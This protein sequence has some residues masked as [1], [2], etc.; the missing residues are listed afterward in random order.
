[1]F[2]SPAGLGPENDCAAEAQQSAKTAAKQTQSPH[3]KADLL[4]EE[5]APIVNT[6]MLSR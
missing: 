4:V 1:M 6:Y 5:E 2:T 3:G